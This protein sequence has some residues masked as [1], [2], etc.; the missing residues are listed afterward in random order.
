MKFIDEQ[1]V[2]DLF[3]GS[4]TLA[5]ALRSNNIK[6]ISND[7]QIYSSIFTKTYLSQ[8]DWNVYPTAEDIVKDV[9]KIIQSWISEFNY[10]WEKI[11]L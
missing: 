11:Q 3:A 9:E 2:C 7:I 10:Y 5:G 6:F 8:F 4:S 1:V